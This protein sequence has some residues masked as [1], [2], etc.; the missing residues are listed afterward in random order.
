MHRESQLKQMLPHRCTARYNS[1]I[2]VRSADPAQS[3]LILYQDG[4][5]EKIQVIVKEGPLWGTDGRL[6]LK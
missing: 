4:K 1:T 5:R 3:V 2:N 6:L